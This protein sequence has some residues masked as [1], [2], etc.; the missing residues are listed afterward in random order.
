MSKQILILHGPNLNLLGTRQPEVYG[1]T[2]LANINQMLEKRAAYLG[3]KLRA[4]QSN[5]EGALVDQLHEARGWA[6]GVVFNAG[7]YTHT[8]YALRDAITAI[9]IPVVE[10]HISNV[11]ARE[12]I[13]ASVA[14]GGGLPRLHRRIR[15]GQLYSG[16]V[17]AAAALGL[18]RLDYNVC[19]PERAV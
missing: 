7:A 8:S 10:V 4:A 15:R 1:A 18:A 19:N 14:A 9:E 12:G 16:A 13:P 11:H 6:D 2:T 5:S 17:W 3:V